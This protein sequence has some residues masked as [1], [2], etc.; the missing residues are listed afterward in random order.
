[1]TGI[2]VIKRVR[3]VSKWVIS[4]RIMFRLAM[5]RNRSVK[6]SRA[7]DERI[8]GRRI[9]WWSGNGNR[10][11]KDRIVSPLMANGLI[12]T[13]GYECIGSSVWIRFVID[14]VSHLTATH[15]EIHV[16]ATDA[17]RGHRHEYKAQN[18]NLLNIHMDRNETESVKLLDKWKR[19]LKTY[20]KYK[21]FRVKKQTH[22]FHSSVLSVVRSNSRTD[23]Q[24]FQWRMLLNLE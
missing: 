14:A 11:A 18:N 21:I 20:I 13:D 24:T 16:T 5:G 10:N 1:M 8:D 17:R 6:A 2:R 9:D 7:V 12:S 4:G 15:V 23:S 3:G 22:G 19:I